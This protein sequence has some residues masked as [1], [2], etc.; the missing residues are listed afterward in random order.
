M[1]KRSIK[2]VQLR[3]ITVQLEQILRNVLIR[4]MCVRTAEHV[5]ISH[6]LLCS[7]TSV[8]ARL[9]ILENYARQVRKTVEH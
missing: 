1:V 3:V 6:R 8:I 9:D 7:D 5:L 4:P 2:H